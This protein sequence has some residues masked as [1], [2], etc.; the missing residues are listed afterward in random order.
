MPNLASVMPCRQV[1]QSL[2]LKSEQASFLRAD[3][4]GGDKLERTLTA[5]GPWDFPASEGTGQDSSSLDSTRRGSIAEDGRSRC[6]EDSSCASAAPGRRSTSYD[7]GMPFWILRSKTRLA[8]RPCF[9]MQQGALRAWCPCLCATMWAPLGVLN[10]AECLADP[11]LTLA[12][13][14]LKQQPCASPYG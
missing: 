4:T 11:L 6:S 3:N 5:E 1:R 2:G 13:S 12:A 8:K 9:Y 10:C 14:A 7:G